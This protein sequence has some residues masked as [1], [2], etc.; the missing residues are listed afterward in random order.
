MWKKR[1]SRGQPRPIQGSG[2]QAS[3]RFLGPPSPRHSYPAAH[4]MRNNNQ[5]LHGDQ[6]RCEENFLYGHAASGRS[7][8]EL[9]LNVRSCN[10][11]VSVDDRWVYWV[12]TAYI[13]PCGLRGCKNWPAPFPGRMS[14]PYKKATKP[15]LVSVLYLSMRYMVLLFIRAPFICC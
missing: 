4:S 15:G 10:H 7:M 13:A 5:I 8:V 3:P 11:R 6:T 9:Q 1:V 2:A 12:F 14:R